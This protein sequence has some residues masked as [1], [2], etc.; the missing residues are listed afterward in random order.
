MRQST[1]ALL[2]LLGLTLFAAWFLQTHHK[3]VDRQFVGYSGE[4]RYNDFLAAELL[5]KEAAIEADSRASLTPSEWLPSYYDTIVS[6]ASESM[7]VTE[8]QSL[9]LD[10]VV[11]GGHLVLLPPQQESRITSEFIQVFGAKLV[12]IEDAP[13]E[14]ENPD[15]EDDAAADEDYDYFFDLSTSLQRVVVS[16]ANDYSATLYDEFGYIAVRRRWGSGYVTLIADA[17]YFL[18]R[19]L[20]D[21]DHARF[22]LDVVAGFVP[23]GKVWFV[24]DSTFPGLWQLIWRNGFYAVVAA[25]AALLLWLWSVMPKF[26][27]A[28]EPVVA[29]RRSILEHVSAAGHFAWR[30]HGTASLARSSIDAL[31]HDAETRHPD[32]SRMSPENQA[33][34]LARLSDIDA[35]TILDVLLHQSESRHREF[36]NNIQ[37]LQKVR[38]RL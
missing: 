11:N 6:R 10:W 1:L 31:L 32:I 35:Q 33:Q 29:S 26:G 30:H 17:E 23:P 4:A 34:A 38:K 16:D 7:A 8:Q 14:D 3:V 12:K 19:S 37:A 36:A 2:L 13:E 20:G 27:P 24:L 15:T 5:L 28:I 9:L 25:A 18:N 21:E 22:L